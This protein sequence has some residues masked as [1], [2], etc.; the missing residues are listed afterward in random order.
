VYPA[1][2]YEGEWAAGKKHGRGT[3]WVKKGG[4]LQKRYAGDW[5]AGRRHGFGVFFFDNGDRFEGEFVEGKR[6]GQGTMVYADGSVY[7]GHWEAGQRSGVGVLTTSGGDAYEGHWVRDVKHGPGRLFYRR[8]KKMYEGEWVDGAPR[9]GVFSAIPDA[10][11]ASDAADDDFVLPELA[12]RDPDA[13]IMEAVAEAR[14]AAAAAR[15]EHVEGH[16]DFGAEAAVL[17]VEAPGAGA[18]EAGEWPAEALSEEELEEL[19]NAFVCA[20]GG[21]SEDR[22]IADEDLGAVLEVLGLTPTDDDIARILRLGEVEA[23]GILSFDSFA[24]VMASLRQ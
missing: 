6:N 19:W 15:G 4:E 22:C 10:S 2:Q 13:V 12:L 5:Y 23:G 8:T 24:A 3:Q 20:P 17:G 9:C 18:D 14:A 7:E 21:V 1:T 11:G 16:D